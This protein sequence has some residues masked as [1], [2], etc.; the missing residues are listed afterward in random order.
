MTVYHLKKQVR[1][2][3]RDYKKEKYLFGDYRIPN[4]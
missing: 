2:K 1:K 3:T 4:Q